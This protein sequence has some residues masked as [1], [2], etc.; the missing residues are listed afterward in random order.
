ML[1]YFFFFFFKAAHHGL[2]VLGEG[3]LDKHG[4]EREAQG[5]VRVTDTQL[6]ARGAALRT[7]KRRH[8]G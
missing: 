8:A 5:A 7:N 6:P 1:D 3:V 2:A 4:S